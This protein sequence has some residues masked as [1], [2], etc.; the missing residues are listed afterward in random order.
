MKQTL[1][2]V[3]FESL[4]ARLFDLLPQ[5][6]SPQSL[7]CVI[8]ILL[9]AE[10]SILLRTDTMIDSQIRLLDV[11]PSEEHSWVFQHLSSLR[12]WTGR[13]AP[14]KNIPGFPLEEKL[15]VDTRSFSD[16]LV[17]FS[18]ILPR[19]NPPKYEVILFQSNVARY[20]FSTYHTAIAAMLLRH[21]EQLTSLKRI[22]REKKTYAGFLSLDTLLEVD[23]DDFVRNVKK[24]DTKKL[25]QVYFMG[26]ASV[27]STAY[28]LFRIRNRLSSEGNE[29]PLLFLREQ[30]KKDNSADWNIYLKLTNFVQGLNYLED[31]EAKIV[32]KT[33]QI[34]EETLK[35][36]IVV[37]EHAWSLCK[38][39]A[40]NEINFNVRLPSIDQIKILL[41]TTSVLIVN[42]LVNQC[43]HKI[44]E[45]NL[46]RDTL[47]LYFA[48]LL[49]GAQ[50]L[51]GRYLRI[52]QH[53][54]DDLRHVANEV[55]REF[56]LNLSRFMLGVIGIMQRKNNVLKVQPSVSK[57]EEL[58]GLLYM[59]DRFAHVELGVD[60]RIHIREH[61]GQ[62]FVSEVRH[63]INQKFYRDHLIHV[64]DVFL[65]GHL[66]LHTRFSWIDGE[67]DQFV[68]H[69]SKLITLGVTK[70][71]KR[72]LPNEL[73]R[74]WAAAALLHDI[75]YQFGDFNSSMDHGRYIDLF[76]HLK[77]ATY[78][79]SDIENSSEL[80][81]K[82]Q[83]KKMT[84]H[85]ESKEDY[86]GWL[87]VSGSYNF[88]DHGVLSALW[89]ANLMVKTD[90]GGQIQAKVLDPPLIR[91]Y[92][93]CLHAIAHHNL[94]NHKVRFATHPLSCL[95][96]LCDELQEWGRRRVSI[97]HMVRHIYLEIEQDECESLEGYESL[98]NL[99]SNINFEKQDKDDY[100]EAKIRV[101]SNQPVFN[102]WFTY[103]N[104]VDAHYDAITTFLSKAYNLQHIEL[105]TSETEGFTSLEWRLL[106]NFPNPREY[107]GLTELDIYGLIRERVRVLPE[108]WRFKS[109]DF[110]QAGTVWLTAES[111]PPNQKEM[112]CIA[113]IVRGLGDKEN[114][115]GWQTCEPSR[116][117]NKLV[118]LKRQI[119]TKRALGPERYWLFWPDS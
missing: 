29:K 44:A 51:R 68:N 7:L 74:D 67:E 25:K 82:Q 90:G 49:C 57:M 48:T 117:L 65:L 79:E 3:E 55:H 9:E 87:P 111:F 80:T 16:S 81:P 1:P 100:L 38:D 18:G 24:E 77:D 35:A 72:R 84:S 89:L 21:F 95:L 14:D 109:S 113:I 69:I 99:V 93:Y 112:D 50:R 61:L 66:L 56:L 40:E 63:H 58:D 97:E 70:D 119:L 76:S 43:K 23:W 73:V 11:F 86:Y 36:S 52:S 20:P 106:L 94:F 102:F 78:I 116:L 107:R 37:L 32:S 62:G 30:N 60:E 104:P 53:N 85:F 31:S 75:G 96:R 105:S 71:V 101:N 46:G 15:V 110:A 42:E 27:L 64:I 13:I 54:D 5:V 108:L 12:W 34:N 22:T 2:H 47:R 17:A 115:R 103:H 41:K 118:D 28:S 39:A 26:P 59:V 8:N 10:I 91:E 45:D 88:A 98:A 19:Q 83:L 114:R 6:N 4:T 92:S 33:H